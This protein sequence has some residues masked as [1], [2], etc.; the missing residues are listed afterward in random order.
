MSISKEELQQFYDEHKSQMERPEQIRLSELLV[1]TE[2]KDKECP[3]ADEAAA[4]GREG[5]S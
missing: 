3:P 4:R 5:Q 1:S 2:K